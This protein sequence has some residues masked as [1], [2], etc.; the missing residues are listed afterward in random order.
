[1]ATKK[2]ILDLD[3]GVDD[4]LALALAVEDPRIDLIGIVSSYGN[5]L[6]ETAGQNSLNLLHLLGADDV[7]VYLGESHSSTTTHFDVMPISMAIH[8]DNGV[9]NIELPQAPRKIES[10]SGVQFLIDA[11]HQYGDDLIYL[12]TGPLTNLAAAIKQDPEVAQLIGQTTLM[13]GALT[14]PGNVTPF[15][16]A[17]I[18]QDPEAADFVFTH[19]KNLTMV[20]LDVTLRTLLTKNHTQAWRA[21]DTL[22]GR[23]YADV[24]DYYINAYDTLDIDHRGAALHDPL[25]VAVAIDPDYVTT[26][27][28]NTRVTYDKQSG[29][30]G[31][32]IGDS[33]RLLDA[34]TTKIAVNVDTERFVRDFQEFM[35]D[36]LSKT[37]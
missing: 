1:M 31:R 33:A 27:N 21:L 16:E 36:I 9:G 8:G 24:M 6:V 37:A 26:I 10:I 34:T 30:Y 15:T 32:T 23:T 18:H 17:N 5:T 35:L 20:G 11:A 12:P 19:Q 13:G 14:V 2:M 3:T 29:D 28:L 7:P 22:A 25:A 4:A